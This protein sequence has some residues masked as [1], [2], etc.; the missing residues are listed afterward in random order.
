MKRFDNTA[1]HMGFV[2]KMAP[3]VFEGI[4][5]YEDESITSGFREKGG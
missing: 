3:N 2:K 4:L 1:L 5:R